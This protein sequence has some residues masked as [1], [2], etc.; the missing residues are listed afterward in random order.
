MDEPLDRRVGPRVR[1][2]F[3]GR[4]EQLDREIE[5]NICV[6]SERE[7]ERSIDGPAV[8]PRDSGAAARSTAASQWDPDRTTRGLEK[9]LARLQSRS[10]IRVQRGVTQD[11]R[12]PRRRFHQPRNVHHNMFDRFDQDYDLDELL[13][14]KVPDPESATAASQPPRVADVLV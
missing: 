11:P 1:S 13:L 2:C 14:V 7:W 3:G 10:L 8:L 6:G 5:T 9:G 4:A 12:A